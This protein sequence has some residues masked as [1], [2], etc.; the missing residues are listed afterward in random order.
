MIT[1]FCCG[2]EYEAG[3]ILFSPPEV[4]DTIGEILVSKIHICPGCYEELRKIIFMNR[5][6]LGL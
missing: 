5:E 2:E 4:V 6:G 3:A 1:C